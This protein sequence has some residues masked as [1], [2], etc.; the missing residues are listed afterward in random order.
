[1]TR[2]QYEA[3]AHLEGSL[4]SLGFTRLES[5]QLIR[6][7]M[8][9]HRWAERECGDGSDWAI[10]RDE[11][12]VA[13]LVYHGEHGGIYAYRPRKA[14]DRETGALKRMGKIV[15]TR[16]ARESR[17]ARG[18]E[19]PLDNQRPVSAFHQTDPRGAALYILRPGDVPPGEDAAAYYSRGVCVCGR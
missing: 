14:I 13:W 15:A 12:G 18:L 6:I 3:R 16:N 17:L 11:G 8:T 2:K 7:E 19:N 10:E 9:L 5:T 1:M 4:E